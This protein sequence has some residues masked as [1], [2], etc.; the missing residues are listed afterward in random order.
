MGELFISQYA[1]KPRTVGAILPSSRY[2]AAKMVGEINFETANVIVEYGPGTGV[3]TK[4]LLKRRKQ[5]T[6]LLLIEI[7]E[8][9]YQY[10]LEEYSEEKNVHII[11]GS[12]EHIKQY[13]EGYGIKCVDYIVSGL[14]FSSL[15]K[16]LSISILKEA[17]SILRKEGMFITFQYTKMKKM[18]IE[19]FFS[20]MKIQREFLNLPPAYIFHCQK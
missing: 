14:P 10:L 11:H 9:F 4:E 3:F 12:A 2:L 7:N 17:T 6:V 1:K 19:Q 20:S 5:G 8:E 13:L 15:P 18:F 16:N